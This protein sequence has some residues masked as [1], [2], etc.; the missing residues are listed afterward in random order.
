M[1]RED[2]AEEDIKVEELTLGDLRE[3]EGEAGKEERPS[4][5]P[6]GLR[7]GGLG[8][9]GS[10]YRVPDAPSKRTWKP[11]VIA[12]VLFFGAF[13]GIVTI[14]Y[15]A[16]IEYQ[17]EGEFFT[18]RGEVLDY[19]Q[20]YE[21][22]EIPVEGVNVTIPSIGAHA[23]TDEEGKFTIK[24]VP[25]GKFTINFFKRS[26][27]EA[28]NTEYVSLMFTDYT[29][30]SPALF[31]VKITDLAPDRS[32]PV[33]EGEHTIFA[34]VVD[35]PSNTEVELRVHA[36]AFDED[37]NDYTIQFSRNGDKVD[38]TWIGDTP[39]ANSV[40]YSMDTN[41]SK[42][43]LRLLEPGGTDEYARTQV[44]IPQHPLGPGGWETT[45]FTDVSLFVRDTPLTNGT[46]R[47]VL[48]HSNDAT[49]YRWREDTGEWEDWASMTAGQAEFVWSPGETGEHKVHVEA[50]NATGSVSD[51]VNVTM[52]VDD[53]DPVVSPR[54]TR[55]PAV[56]EEATFDPGI[57]VR[58]FRYALPDGNWS[59]WQ[60]RMS[61]VLVPVD[62]IG[63]E[64]Q[65]TFQAMDR[66]GNSEVRN[67]TVEVKHQDQW[68]VDDYGRFFTN[69][70]IC[71]PIQAIGVILAFFGGLM[72]Y[73]R[74]RPT[75][76]MV[77]AMGALIAAY[78]LIGAIVAATALA[79]VMFSREEFEVPGPRPPPEE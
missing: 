20:A 28:V 49:E 76:V 15:Q 37:L 53:T 78:G 11:V 39:Y 5:A 77:G 67:G 46:P 16:T 70:K 27:D 35:W 1:T 56:T 44:Q 55:G 13:Y 2:D 12:G 21:Q 42:L 63:D 33:Y 36:T 26:W 4:K 58:Y 45:T 7:A 71:I 59:A 22:A 62:D 52:T 25:G 40:L 19:D 51:P 72:A 32:R 61:E 75:M 68:E 18:L 79:L 23:V 8:P 64:A 10:S 17:A 9:E 69:L 30:A 60:F 43:W 48:V 66:Y 29:E 65:V 34:E 54:S 41:Q 3:A 6:G 14:G 24:D 57:E 31:L 47:T 74:K 50:R 38:A 73:R